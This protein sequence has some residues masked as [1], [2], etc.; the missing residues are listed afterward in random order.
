MR[1]FHNA[2]GAAALALALML[3]AGAM[4]G[5]A[6]V[7][8]PYVHVFVDGRPVGFDV[9]PQIDNGRVLV[10]LRGVFERLGATVAWDDRTQTVLAQRGSTYV[11]LVIGNTRAMIDGRPAAMDVPAM[12]VGGRTMVPLRFVSQALGATV[13][14]DASTSTVAIASS[15]AAALPPSQ[16]YTPPP[17]VQHVV[18]TIVAVRLPVDPGSAGAI[19]VSHNGTISTYRVTSTTAI[20][21]INTTTGAGGSVAIGALR[22]GDTVDIFVTPDNVA[23]RIRATTAF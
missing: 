7:S 3:T 23:Q 20:T 17:P 2:S 19:V 18:G 9:P 12:L 6:Q 14:W 5:G 4:P 13:N 11:S 15:G 16:T 21:R 8:A 10:P 22:A 1:H